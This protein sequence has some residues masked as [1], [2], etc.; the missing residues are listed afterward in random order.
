MADF[1][2]PNNNTFVQYVATAAE[3]NF[4]Y[5]WAIFEDGDLVVHKTLAGTTNPLVLK[6]GVDYTV[7]GAG[8]SVGGDVVLIVGAGVGDIMT[9]ELN[10]P[11][12]RL[13]DYAVT[14]DVTLES[15]NVE[16]DKNVMRDQQ[17]RA[18]I[19]N[20][21]LTYTVDADLGLGDV[22]L[23]P[24]TANQIWKKNSG[25]N[26]VAVALSENVDATALRDDLASQT[27]VAP[28]TDNVGYF[29]TI[30]TVGETLTTTLARINLPTDDTNTLVKDPVDPT[31][32]M[33]IDVGAVT[34][35]TTRVLTMPDQDVGGLASE[36]VAGFIELAST[37]E[38]ETGADNTKAITS[39]KIK[40]LRQV[41]IDTEAAFAT[42]T[43]VIPLD[44]SAPQNT[45]GDQYMTGTYTPK[46]AT[47]RLVIEVRLNGSAANGEHVVTALFQDAIATSLTA[48]A[49]S[50]GAATKMT[51]AYLTHTMVAGTTSAITF[52]VRAGQ[53]TA[54]TFTFNGIG[55]ARIFG[56]VM[57][58]SITVTEIP[59]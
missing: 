8:T 43:T 34:T 3:T 6:L 33:R 55:G 47:N 50:I 40:I 17:L 52:N 27:Q 59:A 18:Q 23:P 21:M 54:G 58:S 38:A 10:L 2:I 19:V 9:I 4:T 24:L 49:D 12:E 31:K 14:S 51:N 32:R 36:T 15:L 25:G 16:F 39:A 5:A 45:E 56:G 41:I 11:F 26:L 30:D 46:S 53:T 48:Q 42:G 44:D 57:E 37:V 7:T 28:G 13:T 22:T 1:P 20:R 29:N 35:A